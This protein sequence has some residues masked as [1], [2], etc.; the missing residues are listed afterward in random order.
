M[1]TVKSILE[2]FTCH[3]VKTIDSVT[4]CLLVDLKGNCYI[5]QVGISAATILFAKMPTPVATSF[6]DIAAAIDA[7]W[8]ADIDEYTYT[9]LFQC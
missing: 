9:Y 2:N 5:Q 4:Y 1:N 7:Y 8:A 3:G 6:S